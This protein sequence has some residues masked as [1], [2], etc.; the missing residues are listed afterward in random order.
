MSTGNQPEVNNC[1]QLES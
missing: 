1:L